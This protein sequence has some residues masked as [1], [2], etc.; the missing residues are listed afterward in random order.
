MHFT[1]G[2]T[3]D[4]VTE[5]LFTV[6]HIPGVLWSPADAAGRRPLLL[7]G[8]GGGHHKKAPAI[9][10][11]ARRYATAFG[12]MVAAI[13]APGHGDQPKSE[14][15]ERSI[16]VIR[17]RAAAGE[18]LGPQIARHNA[19]LA[20]RA[21]PEWVATLDALQELDAVGAGG[22][23]G[24]WGVSMGG[25]IGVPFAAADPRITAA[26]FGLA[27][28]ETL[29]AAAARI[30]VP[31]EYLLQWDDEVVPR[32]SGL[33]LFDAFASREKT[34]HANPGPHMG[35]P[36]FEMESSERFFARHLLEGGASAAAA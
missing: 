30:T 10:A 4:G 15:A 2:T 17:E 7:L 12:F 1:S 33:T 21:V 28:G 14:Q 34:L 16:A 29:A 31:V 20:E 18:P 8:H 32:Q 23:V 19:A 36:A 13:D 6:D 27:G 35:V 26:V 25:G 22:P 11:R 24:Y 9:L 5:R 3:T